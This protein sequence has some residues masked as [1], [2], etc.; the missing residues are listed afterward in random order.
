MLL[1]DLEGGELR[2][3]AHNEE[4][5]NLMKATAACSAIPVGLVTHGQT[6]GIITF[7]CA[8]SGRHYGQADSVIAQDLARRCAMALNNARLFEQT[9]AA[10][11]A[12][13][14]FI[15]VASHELKTPLTPLQ[16]H[17]NTW[18]R[19]IGEFAKEGKEEWVQKR[20]RS[21]QRQSQ[22]LNHLVEELLDVSLAHRR[23][24]IAVGAG[25]RGPRDGRADRSR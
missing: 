16:L 1:A 23:R 7:V 11:A 15:S 2:R 13:E 25:V 6:L 19:R 17:L 14:D 4:H 3:I 20:L 12:R 24:T 21:L 5:F 10:V 22:R 18:Q 8:R 9:R